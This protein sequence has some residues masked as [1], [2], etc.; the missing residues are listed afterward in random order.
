[1]MIETEELA[2]VSQNRAAILE[3][4]NLEGKCLMVSAFENE[5]KQNAQRCNL[6]SI[7]RKFE[8]IRKNVS[9]LFYSFDFPIRANNETDFQNAVFIMQLSINNIKKEI[10]GTREYISLAQ[11]DAISR[12]KANE[13]KNCIVEI[14]E[15]LMLFGESIKNKE[16]TNFALL[17]NISK[18]NGFFRKLKIETSTNMMIQLKR[19]TNETTK[20][21]QIIQSIPEATNDNNFMNA[22]IQAAKNII[23]ESNASESS[24]QKIRE[25]EDISRNLDEN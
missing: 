24:P 9:K 2:S 5:Q 20:L 23:A 19:L 4:V 11:Q 15:I 7:R 12:S 16:V 22:A 17:N 14:E 3:R 10:N 6:V 13:A 21:G 8:G 18:K 1:M 25:S